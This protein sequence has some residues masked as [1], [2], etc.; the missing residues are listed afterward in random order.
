MDAISIPDWRI[1]YGNNSTFDNFN[2]KPEDAPAT[3]VIAIAYYDCDN[4]RRL[5][6]E[7]DFY[8]WDVN[9]PVGHISVVNAGK[10][11]WF[12]GDQYGW[13]QYMYRPGIKIVKFG[14]T[15]DDMTWRALI[16][17]VINDLPLELGDIKPLKGKKN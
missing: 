11:Q 2:G 12:G 9:P 14:A 6:S 4:R 8:W 15:Y 13:L 16:T 17:K 1:Y 10:P 3:G 7:K 5:W